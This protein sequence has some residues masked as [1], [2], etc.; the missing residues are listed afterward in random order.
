[1][2]WWALAYARPMRASSFVWIFVPVVA[3]CGGAT[4]PPAPPPPAPIGTIT[5]NPTPTPGGAT[6]CAGAPPAADYECVQDCGPP[7][8]QP[9]DPPPGWHWL[10]PT[11]AKNRKQFGCPICL[12]SDVRIA[13]PE[14]ER[15]ISEIAVGARV[16]TLDAQGQRVEARVL[17]VGSTPAS[18]GHRLVRITLA[19]GR[20]VSGS[21]GHPIGEGRTLADVRARD[22]VSGAPV[23]GVESVPLS[24]DRT[25]DIL[26]SGPTGLYFANGV[27]LKSSLFSKR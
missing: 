20:V 23:V 18:I 22:L 19:D 8:A 6:K 11:D 7:V 2:E 17:H 12:P 4:L 14:G 9:S 25:W 10:S 13:T 1:M 21:A 26:P 24:G 16:Y 5:P 27:L 15:P 3:A